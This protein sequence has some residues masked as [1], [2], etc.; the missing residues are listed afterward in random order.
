MG[1]STTSSLL[2]SINRSAILD[3]I[4]ERGP[5]ART[6]IAT[7]L[8]VS[9][10]TV[11][12]VVDELIE[13]NLVQPHG[14]NESTRGRPRPLLT[15][16]PSAYAVIGVDL[17]STKMLGALT[18]LSGTI[19]HEISIPRTSDNPEANLDQLCTLIE[20][21]LAEPRLPTQ[22][23]RGIG[24]G[25]PGV[26]TLA[27]GMVQWAPSLGW[28]NF[29][30]RKYVQDRFNIPVFIENDVNLAALGE[31]AFGAGR[32]TQ[33]LVCINIGTGIGA[34]IIIGGG[35]YRGHHQAAGEIGYLLPSVEHL[36]QQYDEFGA[37]EYFA[38]GLGIARRARQT[39]EH[40]GT[41]PP[42][43]D[44]NAEEVFEAARRGEGWAKQ[45]VSDTVD[46]IGLAVAAV[47]ALFDPEVIVLGGRVA[48]SAD[49]LVEQ[50]LRRIQGVVPYAPR[51]VASPL[52]HHAT[53]KGASLLVL[54]G[55]M[56]SVRIKQFP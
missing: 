29:P 15:F 44:L 13:E 20:K 23:M 32:G 27:E 31:L 18:D 2:R 48:Y 43:G 17:A 52:G 14:T 42:P 4:R 19:Q 41:P 46:Y 12:R 45:V 28:R 16:N 9:L 3:L 8:K 25:V 36:G 51:F 39:L 35:L 26:V 33:N 24:L 10:P 30:L 37:L 40:T 6:Q 50:I 5:I 55:T 54:N 21:L 11:M 47:S 34:G 7:Q 49:L 1:R 56:D 22:V 53:V 38:A